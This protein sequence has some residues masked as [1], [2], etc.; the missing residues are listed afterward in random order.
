MRRT[1]CRWLVILSVLFASAL[2]AKGRTRPHYGGTLR[3]ES[4]T[5]AL[6]APDAPSRKLLFDT[7]TQ[8]NAA[9]K[10]VPGLA[11]RWEAQSGN[12]R[13][14]FYLRGG[15]H[16]HDGTPLTAETVVQALSAACANCGWRARAVGDSVVITSESPLPGMPEELA[17]RVY[18]VG[19]RDG[20]G[21]PDGT[22]PF[23]FS[24]NSNGIL[25][26]IANE[27][28]WGGRPFPDA[29]EVYGN[30]SVREQW[31]DFAAGKADLVEVPANLQRPAQ[32][33][34]LPLLI[35]GRP[36]DLLVLTVSAS[37]VK[38]EHLRESIALAVDRT[39]LSNVIFQKQ[40]EITASLLPEAL[41]GYG[42]LFPSA[43][44]PSRARTLRGPQSAPLR[45]AVD[46][47]D[48][49]MQLTAER[50]ALNLR[51]AGWNVRVVP[52]AQNPNAELTLRLIHGESADAPSLLR[53][54]LNRFG[55]DQTED[56]R[57]P[58]GLYRMEQAFLQEHTVIPLLYLPR[59]Y[60]VSSR[61]HS[62]ELAPDGTPI[63]ANAWLEDTR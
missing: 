22:G 29:V 39:A 63:L 21:N 57:E 42:F 56:P 19:R 13:W 30:R 18:A 32:E 20:A 6:N 16:F 26:L 25:F 59:A 5:D 14:Q 58:A 62:L 34:H 23:R 50:L 49:V 3:V 46:A 36:S 60:G 44:D 40:G 47:S 35:A 24:A 7:L 48:A 11:V 53:E 43:P 33:D 52:L 12:H 17:R 4:R 9:G 41:S 51:D 10:V 27:D 8:T 61:V 37:A 54:T 15:V 38:D 31:L 2:T 45:L 28:Y 1:V 55:S